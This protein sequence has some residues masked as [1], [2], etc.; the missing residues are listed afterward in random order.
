VPPEFRPSSQVRHAIVSYF[1]RLENAS[2]RAA[3]PF[4]R[5]YKCIAWA[6]CRTGTIWWPDEENP[7]PIGVYWPPW[8]ARD[9]RLDTFVRVFAALGY[10]V[11]DKDDFEF[12]Y[13]KVAMY[14]L[15]EE[16]VTHM[17][18]QHFFGRGWLSKPGMLED[19][20]HADLKCIE[21]HPDGLS[22]YGTVHRIMRRSWW[23]ALVN[24]CLFRCFWYALKFWLCRG[25][26]QVLEIKWKLVK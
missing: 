7:L 2:W 20:V 12:G 22:D 4:D 8:A 16:H 11:C 13:Q 5:S 10:E 25:L 18:R 23:V 21:T 15:N 19:I 3:S 6:A 9:E 1:P 24:L 26:W 14:A 17:A